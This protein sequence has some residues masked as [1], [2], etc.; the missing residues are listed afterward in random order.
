MQAVFLGLFLLVGEYKADPRLAWIP[1]DL[2]VGLASVLLLFIAY[3]L[4]K[5]D[6]KYQK[7]LV[8]LFMGVAACAIPLLWTVW[9]DFAVEKASRMFTLTLLACAA[10]LLI[11]RDRMDARLLLRT[12]TVIGLLMA[13]DALFSLW[14]DTGTWKEESR[15][16]A[17]G[18]N[19]IALGRAAGIALIGILVSHGRRRWLTLAGKALAILV[20]VPVIFAS[21]SRGPLIAIIVTMALFFLLFNARTLKQWLVMLLTV[22][23][24]ALALV[25]GS[26]VAPQGSRERIE[27]SAN[28]DPTEDTRENASFAARYQAVKLSLKRIART[29]LGLGWGGFAGISQELGV[30]YPHNLIVETFVEGGWVCGVLLCGTLVLLFRKAVKLARRSGSVT[31]RWVFLLAVFM[32]INSLMSGD[33]NDNRLLFALLALASILEEMEPG[34]SHKPSSVMLKLRSPGRRWGMP[35]GRAASFTGP[36]RTTAHGSA[37]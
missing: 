8:Y 27:Q 13:A 30:T 4:A 31:D 35:K 7:Q 33:I 6:V 16:T 11:L 3:H 24:I 29:P 32:F 28:A 14:R 18:S 37:R 19:T 1:F 2:T 10:P 25:V 17:M 36:A 9:T 23:I 5:L 22:G 15:L 12:L 21:G 34:R 20:L 26:M